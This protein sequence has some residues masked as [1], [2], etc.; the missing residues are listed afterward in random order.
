MA[1]FTDN[2]NRSD[3]ELNGDNG[4]VVS[5]GNGEYAIK[6]NICAHD[7]SNQTSY[8]LRN[9][10][11]QK[12]PI[13]VTFY[14][15]DAR[16]SDGRTS[17]FANEIYIGCNSD[18]SGAINVYV[19]RS[20]SSYNNSSIQIY[21]GATLVASKNASFQF[22]SALNVTTT[23]NADG[24]GSIRVTEGSNSDTL[25]WGARTWSNGQGTYFGFFIERNMGV[26]GQRIDDLSINYVALAG[27]SFGYVF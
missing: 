3:R 26:R 20:N 25:T 2:F 24:S 1:V 11:K 8:V 9:L 22:Q 10:G 6:S 27:R 21:D 19:S 17:R 23:I 16:Y 13:T 18:K 4:W 5:S 14:T 12:F 7:G 15:E